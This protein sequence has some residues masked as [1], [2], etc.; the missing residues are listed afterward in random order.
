MRLLNPLAC[1]GL[2]PHFLEKMAAQGVL[3]PPDFFSTDESG[4]RETFAAASFGGGFR[5]E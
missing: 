2:K 5:G 4:L 3:L 1:S